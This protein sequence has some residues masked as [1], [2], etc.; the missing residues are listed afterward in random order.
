MVQRISI[1]F[2]RRKHHPLND[3]LIVQLSS[4]PIF[5]APATASLFHKRRN[6]LP[7]VEC[8][9]AKYV[10]M[11]ARILYTIQKVIYS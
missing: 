5:P 2:R 9:G 11:A 7:E 4:R 10:K 3:I 8:M 1:F 6:L